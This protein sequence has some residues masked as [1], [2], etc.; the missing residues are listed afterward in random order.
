[1]ARA[2]PNFFDK[3]GDAALDV[4]LLMAGA[5]ERGRL[6]SRVG[7]VAEIEARRGA[8]MIDEVHT[9]VGARRGW[10]RAGR[11]GHL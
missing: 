2:S 9:L 10:G 1:M 7:L 5:K 4:G 11:D 3:R 8:L 6:E